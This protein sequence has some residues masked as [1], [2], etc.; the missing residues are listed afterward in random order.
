MKERRENKSK[1]I[2]TLV[3]A[4]SNSGLC[5]RRS[6][7]TYT[8]FDSV[9]IGIYLKEI[10]SDVHR[11]SSSYSWNRYSNRLKKS[12]QLIGQLIC[13]SRDIYKLAY[14]TAT[15]NLLRNS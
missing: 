8:P 11:K 13:Q 5:F 10:I 15:G 6:L 4:K 1:L 12:K 14:Y 9:T 3:G 2:L 7:E